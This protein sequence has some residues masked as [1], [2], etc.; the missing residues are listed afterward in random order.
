MRRTHLCIPVIA[1]LALAL[2]LC[3]APAFATGEKASASTDLTMASLGDP[4]IDD[5][6][7]VVPAGG[8]AMWRLYNPYSGEHFYTAD[9]DERNDLVK[10]GWN[11]EGVGWF[12]PISSGTPVYRLY[13]KF[14]GEHHYTMDASERASLIA[15]GWADEGIGWYSVDS[16]LGLGLFRDYNP[17]AYANNHN[18][19]LSS[20]EHAVLMVAGWSPEGA[21]W[22]GMPDD[23]PIADGWYYAS[24]NWHYYRGGTGVSGEW[25]VTDVSPA[26]GREFVNIQRYWV[27]ANGNLAINRLID[28]SASKDAAAGYMA[29]ATNGAAVARGKYNDGAG[30]VYVADN[31]G[32]LADG[33]GWFVTDQ[34]DGGYERYYMDASKHAAKVGLLTVDGVQY[35][36][37]PDAGYIARNKRI[38]IGGVWKWA[39]ADTGA[40][41]DDTH[42]NSMVSKAQGYY[43]PSQYMLMVDIDDPMLIIFQGKKGAWKVLKVCDCCTGA[44]W[45]PTVTGVFSVGSKGYSFGEGH[46]YSCYYYTQF[47]GDYLFHTRKYY[48][49]THVLLDD[50]IGVRCSMG[51][52]RLYDEDAIWIQNNCPVGTTVVCTT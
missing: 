47:Y 38:E 10:L 1:A 20:D 19:T 12:A 33:D 45:S 17:N 7:V 3:V 23:G 41:S 44:P 42:V 37:Q 52:V 25:V 16:G 15:A 40:L 13:N 22:Y 34:Y 4:V 51:C 49:G 24:G 46:G 30:Y 39:A 48:P 35:Y 6:G 29:F 21:S 26:V 27:D 36:G 28:P 18:Y 11:Y 32:R 43:S 9:K 5:S 2:T 31:D 8:Q 14:G 50:S